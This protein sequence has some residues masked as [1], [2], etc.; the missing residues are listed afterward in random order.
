[1]K[2]RVSKEKIVM[3]VT[4]LF[5]G[6]VLAYVVF[7]SV[8]LASFPGKITTPEYEVTTEG[9]KSTFH[10]GVIYRYPGMVPLLSVSG[11]HYEMGLQYGVLLRP[12]IMKA[13]ETYGKILRWEAKIVFIDQDG[14]Y[15]SITPG[16]RIR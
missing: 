2:G 7:E 12:E 14:A 3:S 5:T 8:R 4:L 16:G 11:D 1:M 13:L 9:V 6:A 15:L 10:D